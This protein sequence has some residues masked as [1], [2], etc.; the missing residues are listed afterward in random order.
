MKPA[1]AI[2]SAEAAAAVLPPEYSGLPRPK[3]IPYLPSSF[4]VYITL[5]I[6]CVLWIVFSIFHLTY[7]FTK[8]QRLTREGEATV[9]TIMT[10]YQD[11]GES[12]TCHVSYDFKGPDTQGLLTSFH[13]RDSVSCSRYSNLTVG[14]NIEILYAASDPSLSAI[15]ETFGSRWQSIGVAA[16]FLLVGLGLLYY[17]LNSLHLLWQ[18][19]VAGQQTQAILFDRWQDK[20]SE[21]D[22]NYRVAYA[23][24]ISTPKGPQIITGAIQNQKLYENYKVGNCLT[25]CY[26]PKKPEISWVV[27]DR[28]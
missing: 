20:D 11:G 25:V 6:F 1:P 17:A 19:R 14:Q 8:Y 13:D 2:P 24:K 4:I 12:P 27:S 7:E 3:T 28:K 9:A 18:L 5:L 16:I 26:L 21:G 22:V 10:L 15:K 23:F